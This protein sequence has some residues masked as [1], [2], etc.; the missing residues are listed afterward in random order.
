MSRPTLLLPHGSGAS[1]D[2][3]RRHNLSTILTLV[4]HEGGLPR[5]QLTARTGLNRSTVAALVAELVSLQL[6]FESEPDPTKQAG[7]PS[8]IVR[9]DARTVAI[10]INPEVDAV[11]IGV[12]GL[13]GEVLRRVRHETPGAPTAA[14]VVKISASIIA[15]FREEFD[16]SGSIVGIGVAVPGLVRHDD[17]VVSLAPH[18]QWTDE[19]IATMLEQ[20][21]GL[22]VSAGNDARL[23]A[24]AEHAYG[25]GRGATDLIYLNGGASGIGGGII[26]GGN[27]LTGR[28]GYAGEFGHIR[29]A[30]SDSAVE[31]PESGS[32]ESEVNRAA[33]LRVVG[34]ATADADVLER[35]LL[36]STD[37]AVLAL[38]HRQ[39]DA[40]SISLRNAVNVLNPEV[41]VLGGFLAS[42]LAVDPEYLRDRVEKQA[43]APSFEGVSIVGAQLGSNLL[44]IGAAEFAFE[45]VLADPAARR[46]P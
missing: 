19:P 30:P 13:G 37:P 43:L 14:E 36:A 9:P 35:A 10:A 32:L 18:L 28:A 33:L 16:S 8:P 21:T 5:S 12:V 34:L 17:G 40:L 4:H 39:L 46:A 7:R 11:T 42:I 27:L 22:P 15:S 24:S 23:G 1:T 29:I 41:I 45:A 38:V 25:A 31:D 3:T 20:A 2:G 6:V 44:M 26:S